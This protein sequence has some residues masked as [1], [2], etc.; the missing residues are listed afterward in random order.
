MALFDS[1]N[2]VDVCR[3]PGERNID[4]TVSPRVAFG[5]ASVMLWGGIKVDAKTEFVVN[6]RRNNRGLTEK[7][8]VND[9]VD[10]HIRTL[11]E[12]LGEN[13]T[14]AQDIACAYIAEHVQRLIERHLIN[15]LE[16]P[17]CSR[18]LNLRGNL[19]DRLKRQVRAHP[20]PPQTFNQLE[21][22]LQEGWQQ[23]PSFE[24]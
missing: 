10:P 8:Y 20:Y 7:R 5:G 9:I 17:P 14:L 21:E 4:A 6:R 3:R 1:D 22:T 11:V 13:L 12:N 19:W 15:L 18:D 24:G 2:R 23:I 16:W